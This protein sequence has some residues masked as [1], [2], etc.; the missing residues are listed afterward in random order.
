MN[1]LGISDSRLRIEPNSG[2]DVRV[3]G[4]ITKLPDRPSA[5]VTPN[6]LWRA[7]SNFSIR[8]KGVK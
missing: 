7:L 4:G 5:T 1:P 8:F 6:A 3:E 2:T